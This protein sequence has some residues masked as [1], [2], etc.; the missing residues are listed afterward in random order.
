MGTIPKYGVSFYGAL[1]GR[2]RF[3]GIISL[4][5]SAGFSMVLSIIIQF[6]VLWK[7]ILTSVIMPVVSIVPLDFMYLEA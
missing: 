7:S 3:A 4:S 1:G 6:I 5:I 2:V